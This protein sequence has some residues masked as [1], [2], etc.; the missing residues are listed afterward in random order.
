LISAFRSTLDET[1]DAELLLHVID[2]G[3][4]HIKEKI[5]EV[6]AILSQLGVGA[7]P[8]LHVLNKI[9]LVSKERLAE[10]KQ[11]FEELEPIFVSCISG[12]GLDNLKQRIAQVLSG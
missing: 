4:E 10:L 2:A 11:T 12:D 9:D 6:D 7:T 1:I 3:D 8:R 5:N